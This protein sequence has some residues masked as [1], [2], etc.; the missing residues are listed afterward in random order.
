MKNPYVCSDD[1]II[2]MVRGFSAE[3]PSE[4]LIE[5]FLITR[6]LQAYAYDRGYADA[7]SEEHQRC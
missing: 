7:L 4:K 3:E 1:E 6:N 5:L 2:A